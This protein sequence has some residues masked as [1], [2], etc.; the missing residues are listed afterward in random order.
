M[1][2]HTNVCIT[3]DNAAGQKLK[4]IFDWI[5]KITLPFRWCDI[6]EVSVE[7]LKPISF[8]YNCW[9]SAHFY[10]GIAPLKGAIF[11]ENFSLKRIS[12]SATIES[13]KELLMRTD[14]P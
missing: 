8:V 6:H 10:I 12:N 4:A 1:S 7:S 11:P 9:D 14:H 3:I 13:W 5:G 2:V